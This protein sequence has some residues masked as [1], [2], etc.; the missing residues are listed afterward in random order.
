MSSVVAD[1]DVVAAMRGQGGIYLIVGVFA[2]VIVM[3]IVLVAVKRGVSIGMV[4][5]GLLALFVAVVGLGRGAISC[6]REVPPLGLDGTT[7]TAGTQR[8]TLA[9]GTRAEWAPVA[10]LDAFL[11]SPVGPEGAAGSG[12]LYQRLPGTTFYLP[13]FDGGP[14]VALI[15]GGNRLTFRPAA[16]GGR[17]LLGDR[18]RPEIQEIGDAILA[19]VQGGEAAEWL[20]TQLGAS[21]AAP[22]SLPSR[23]FGPILLGVA[24]LVL[25]GGV[26]GLAKLA[27]RL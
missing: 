12:S 25:L 1:P 15:S 21:V 18:A 27:M 26:A 11:A 13:Y 23:A 4:V 5:G 10:S 17:A 9:P 20:S 8:L 2:L 3:G 16:Y 7:L 19:V 14:E 24:A 22:T 6:L